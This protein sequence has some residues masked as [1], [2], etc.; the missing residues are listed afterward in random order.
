MNGPSFETTQNP[1]DFVTY[2]KKP[3]TDK[4]K[5]FGT[6]MRI[7]GKIESGGGRSQSPVGSTPYF[8]LNGSTPDKNVS[9]SGSSGGLAVLLNP[10][11]NNGYYFELVALT[12]SNI[13]SYA[14]SNNIHN[15]MFYKVMKE[16]G[17]TKAIPVKLWSGLGNI[18]VDDGRFTGQSRI[19][20]EE[21]PTVYDIAVEY[22]DLGAL[23]KFY[24]YV[25]NKLVAEVND[26]SPLPV[27]NNMA[28]F[29]RGSSRLMFE[30]IYAITNNY[31][32]NTTYALDTP[33]NSVFGDSE[34]DNNES[35]RKYAMSGIIQSTYLSGIS[36]LQPPEYKL[37]FEEFG[38]IMRE[39]A[40]FNVRYDKAYPA[41]YAKL[42]P[43]F[44]KIR[45][46]S[47][48]GFVAG[49]Y[50]AEFLVFNATD[51]ALNLDETSGNYLRIQGIT[52][53]QESKHDLSV[54][55]YFSK[56]SDFSNPQFIGDTLVSSPFKVKEAYNDIKTS[57][58][59][60][61]RKDFSLDAPY[62]QTQDDANNLMGWMI[63]KVMKPR[64]SVGL[65]VFAMPTIQ[66]GDIVQI[67]YKESDGTDI[68]A[69]YDTRFV[70]YDIDYSRSVGGP[71]MTI[72]LSEVM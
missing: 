42:S 58:M 26:D 23:R 34:I 37:Y 1:I 57:R 13:S 39:A 30:N 10:E 6:R 21:N 19:V 25:N 61:G 35:F 49:A 44:N 47:V 17:G 70:V 32:Q 55:D 63:S 3:L 46:Y 52:F 48:A 71:E 31:S 9:I 4:F 29:V 18:I 36:P 38:T 56:R 8:N 27:Y 20:G 22:Q 43:T 7:V 64:K 12:D 62:I 33:V 50:G 68:I 54:D 60:H 40:Y 69:P 2:V 65:K 14:G 53:T 45:G 24:L 67:D 28:L 72:Y 51:T 66:L 59:T 5:H 15:L 41:L 11:T 16:A